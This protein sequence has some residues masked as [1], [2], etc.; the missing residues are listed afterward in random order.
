MNSLVQ[1]LMIIGGGSAGWLTAAVIAST[2]KHR[3][4]TGTLQITLCESP[5]IPNIGVGE[6]TWPTMP[7]TLQQIG[8]SESEFIQR[9]DVSFKQGSKFVGWGQDNGTGFYYNPFDLPHGFA[10]GLSVEYWH[11]TQLKEALAHVFSPQQTICELNK[12]PKLVTDAEYAQVLNYGYHLNAGAFVELLKEHA[13]NNLG[14]KHI[15]ANV[16]HVGLA[17]NGD[18]SNLLLDSGIQVT[19]DLFIDCTGFKRLLIEKALKVGFSP[20]NITLFAD[21]ALATQ[22]EYA[23]DEEAI[24]SYTQSTAQTAG[25]IWDIA[26]PNRRGVGHVYASDF[27]TD[28]AAEQTLRQYIQNSGGLVEKCNIRKISFTA[29]HM[30][31]FWHNNCVAVGLSAGFLEPLEAS[32][33]VLIELSAAKIAEVLPVTTDVMQIAEKRFNQTFAYHWQTAVDFLKLHYLMS[34]RTDDFWQENRKTATVSGNLQELMDLWKHSVP[35]MSDFPARAELFHA[36]SYQFVL[37]GHG[38]RSQLFFE[39]SEQEKAYA[40]Q[41][42]QYNKQRIAQLTDALPSNRDLI[43]NIKKYGLSRT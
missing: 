21:T 28:E 19:A 25:W 40:Q 13:I 10:E 14:V 27:Q 22:V 29:G 41:L 2:H 17:A 42:I 32:A 8:I 38:Y 15:V 24:K 6:G 35:K 34:S 5:N 20:L 31:K 26:L 43:N 30:N 11:H 1:N 16:E 36:A 7:K 23:S 18:I 3:I 4:E 37:Y 12:A 39:L 33:L 9:C